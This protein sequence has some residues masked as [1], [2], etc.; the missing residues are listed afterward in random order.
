MVLCVDRAGLVGADGETHHGV[1]DVAYLRQV[2][3]MTVF[4]PANYRE[5]ELM[6]REA[7]L[8]T[9]GPVAVRYPRGREGAYRSAPEKDCIRTGGDLTMVTYGTTVNAVLEAADRLAEQGVEAAVFKLRK[10]KP[11]DTGELFASVRETGRLL[12]AEEVN[13]PGSIC[14]ALSEALAEA[15]IPAQVCA[16][17]LGDRYTTHGATD[18]LEREAGL[19]AAGI[20]RSAMEEWKLESE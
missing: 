11:L 13:Q 17:N 14:E 4:A 15:G 18:I 2:P 16:C 9:E 19:D 3:G 10:L 5:L 1:F 7:V 12:V 8:E 20:L 6:L